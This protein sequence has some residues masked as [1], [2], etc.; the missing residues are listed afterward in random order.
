V[1]EVVRGTDWAGR[2]LSPWTQKDLL[3]SLSR[4]FTV[5]RAVR[6]RQASDF[7]DL[8]LSSPATSNKWTINAYVHAPIA[9]CSTMNC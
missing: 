5:E 2:P 4:S 1:G 6:F 3:R 9:R 7:N 8:A